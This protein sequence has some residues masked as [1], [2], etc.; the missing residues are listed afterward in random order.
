MSFTRTK[1]ADNYDKI[2]PGT[3]GRPSHTGI[4]ELYW[5]AKNSQTRPNAAAL[6]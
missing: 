6:L 2:K 5:M 3:C 4:D 1:Y